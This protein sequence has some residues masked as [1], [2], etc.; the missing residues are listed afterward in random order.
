MLNNLKLLI[1]LGVLTSLF[2]LVGYSVGGKS[3]LIISLVV[4]LATQGLAFWNSDKIA[5]SM[6]QAQEVSEGQAPELYEMTRALAQKAELPMP[7]L[8]IT[9]ERLPNAF[10]TGRDP[11]HSAVAVTQGLLH[12]LSP[13]ELEGVIAHELGHI[14]NRDVFISTVAA[15]LASAISTLAQFS[16]FFGGNREERGGVLPFLISLVVAPF[17]AMIIQFAISRSREFMADATAIALTGKPHGLANAL[18]KLE[19]I[20]RQG[21]QPDSLQPAFSSLYIANP[22]SGNFLSEWMST[23]PPIPKRIERI[24]GAG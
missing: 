6:N 2:L 19:T 7:R 5:L 17:A 10:A 4:A 3:G 21:Y 18:R 24:L 11:E 9:P 12:N 8:Y 13:D 22:F 14:K 20:S 1:L 16:Y 15:I 23:H